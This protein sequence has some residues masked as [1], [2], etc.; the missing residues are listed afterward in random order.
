M[1]DIERLRRD[2]QSYDSRGRSLQAAGPKEVVSTAII[3]VNNAG[4]AIA[5]FQFACRYA[6]M[7]NL[8]FGFQ[9]HSAPPAGRIPVF[10]ASVY[11]WITEDRLPNSR[12]YAGARLLIV[13]E[14][15]SSVA[16]AVHATAT[17]IAFTGP[18]E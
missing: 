10:S 18:L 5:P 15:A 3:K 11:E 17:G 9:M 16:F 4:E 1:R 8:S 12:L 13:S 2:I 6:Q 7:P 14:A